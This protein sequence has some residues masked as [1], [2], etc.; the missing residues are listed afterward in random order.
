MSK[1]TSLS[2]GS[3]F[4]TYLVI[5]LPVAGYLIYSW[6]FSGALFYADDFHLLKTVQWVRETDEWQEKLKLFYQQHQ[7]HRIVV[8]RLLTLA[9]YYLEGHIGWR[10]LI[11]F[12]NIVWCATIFILWKVFR[13]TGVSSWYFIPVPWLLFH[14]QYY[15]NVTWSISILQQSDV[16]FLFTLLAYLCAR[17]RY[18]L[19][20]LISV[21]A[22]FTHGNGLFSFPIAIAF[23]LIDKNRKSFARLVFTFFIVGLIYFYGFRSGQNASI[24]QS[25]ADP[26]NLIQSFGVFFGSTTLIAVKNYLVPA[27][28]GLLLI[29]SLTAWSVI[30][31]K[32]SL[33]GAGSALF[34]RFLWGITAFLFVTGSLVVATRSWQGVETI[35]APRYLHYSSYVLCIFYLLIVRVTHGSIRKAL[36]VVFIPAALLFCLLSYFNFT[37]HVRFLRDQLL[38]EESNYINHGVFLQYFPSFNDNISEPYRNAVAS[39][40]IKMRDRLP[41]DS[42]R[43]DRNSSIPL[44]IAQDSIRLEDASRSSAER[45]V[46]IS[47][48]ERHGKQVFLAIRTEG[49]TPYWIPVYT[50]RAAYRSLLASGAWLGNGFEGTAILNN[51]PPGSYQIGLY[52]EGSVSWTDQYLSVSSERK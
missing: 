25:L 29:G 20:L 38:A 45:I 7:E 6:H 23:S 15:E 49:Q 22:T 2:R 51:L 4:L 17:K 36:G 50:Q 42:A 26:L 3:G 24:S 5:A 52:A 41:Y 21:I 12:A 30:T 40:V 44:V 19:V 46:R 18:N 14:P 13:S 16:V 11:F 48:T 10:S 34:D 9:D 35:A 47:S 43:Q 32:N 28:A 8:P 39:G 27:L 31:L 33:T 37:P 1:N